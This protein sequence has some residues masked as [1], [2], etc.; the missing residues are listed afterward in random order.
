MH[1]VCLCPTYGR[2]SLVANAYSLFLAQSLD[3]G[4][5]AEFVVFDDANQIQS[6]A[7]Q[8][9]GSLGS[10]GLRTARVV[11]ADRWIPLPRKYNRLLAAIGGVVDSPSVTYVVWDDD[12]VYLPW[13]LDTV[14]RCLQAG[15][16]AHPSSVWSTYG[17]DPLQGQS[18]REEDASG[19]FHGALAIRGDALAAVDGW[20][21]TD[22]A[23]YDQQ[24]LG[25]LRKQL[26][27]PADPVRLRPRSYVYRWADTQRW[28]CSGT[29]SEGK[30]DQPPLQELGVVQILR[31]QRDAATEALL[32]HCLP[33]L[34]QP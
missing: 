21:A 3:A 14:G 12:D 9:V 31:P 25:R 8:P 6:I 7:V 20:P 16:W 15:Q 32:S 33:L 5:T 18:P 11:T 27:P 1:Y 24:M 29:I 17:T 10:N 19:L 2:P 13:H 28:H 23:D 4:E 34:S 22:Q 26:G 30:Y